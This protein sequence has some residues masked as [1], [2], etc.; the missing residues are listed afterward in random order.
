M[1]LREYEE[2]INDKYTVKRNSGILEPG[3]I[4]SHTSSFEP[5]VDGPSASKHSFK[6][7]G[8]WRIF[9]INEN[10]ANHNVCGWRRLETIHPT[11]LDDDEEVIVAW[12]ESILEILETL[13]AKRVAEQEYYAKLRCTLC[14]ELDSVCGGNHGNEKR[15]WGKSKR[16]S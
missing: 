13:E 7:K 14:G 16:H 1:S 6:D 3:W 2:I 12:R 10:S 15:D 11:R 5:N 9:M 8:T 4:I